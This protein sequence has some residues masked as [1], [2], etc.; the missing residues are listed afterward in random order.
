MAAYDALPAEVRRVVRNIFYEP[1]CRRILD[2]VR[3]YPGVP[4]DVMAM[5]LAAQAE[6]KEGEQ[7]AQTDRN[8]QRWRDSWWR[9]GRY[10]HAAA[11]ATVLRAETLTG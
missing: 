11:G 5:A 1:V 10:P 8:F 4:P 6:V 2:F 7:I 9:G 3:T